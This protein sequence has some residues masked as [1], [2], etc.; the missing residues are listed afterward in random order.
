ML[1]NIFHTTSGSGTHSS[2]FGWLPETPVVGLLYP[3]ILFPLMDYFK[4][5][6]LDVHT[7]D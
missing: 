7:I 6:L 1:I 3:T 2:N 4:G 5:S